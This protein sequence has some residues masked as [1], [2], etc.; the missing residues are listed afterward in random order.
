MK[1]ISLK[2]LAA[3]LVCCALGM[4]YTTLRSMPTHKYRI[5]SDNQ[6]YSTNKYEV[7][8]YNCI[9]FIDAYGREITVCGHYEIIKNK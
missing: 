3:F 8:D 9:V 7:L 6:G 2:L 1:Q 5:V 4:I